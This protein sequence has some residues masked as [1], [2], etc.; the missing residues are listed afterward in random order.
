[1]SCS[2]C[3]WPTVMLLSTST[4]RSVRTKLVVLDFIRMAR[5]E[6]RSMAH[7]TPSLAAVTCPGGGRADLM[8]YHAQRM[9]L[10][11]ACAATALPPPGYNTG[12]Y[13]ATQ[14]GQYGATRGNPIQGKGHSPSRRAASST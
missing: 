8:R 6:R 2:R 3:S 5:K 10:L 13:G 9:A 7:S 14:T 11:R 12:Q 1:M 4:E